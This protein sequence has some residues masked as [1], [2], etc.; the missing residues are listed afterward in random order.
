METPNG[1]KR[2]VGLFVTSLVVVLPIFGI[3]VSDAAPADIALL[4]EA[5]VGVVGVVTLLWGEY[6]AKAPMWFSKNK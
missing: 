4:V 3:K 5:I 2:T 1:T 6:S